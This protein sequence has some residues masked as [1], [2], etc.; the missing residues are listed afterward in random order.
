MVI[1]IICFCFA[2]FFGFGLYHIVTEWK[3][4]NPHVHTEL[5]V[6][7]IEAPPVVLPPSGDVPFIPF[8]TSA[9]DMINSAHRT[10]QRAAFHAMSS[11]PQGWAP[12][13]F[14]GATRSQS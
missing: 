4:E 12:A 1:G 11:Q 7:V 14:E 3:H 6:A 8:D 9:N 13:M 5:V 10:R 2:T